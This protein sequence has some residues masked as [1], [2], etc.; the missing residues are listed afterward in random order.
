MSLDP[1]G[2]LMRKN[3]HFTILDIGFDFMARTIAIALSKE[4]DQI[5]KHLTHAGKVEK[6]K[7]MCHF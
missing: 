2:N 1:R 3:Q 7:M 6:N 4:K 5:A